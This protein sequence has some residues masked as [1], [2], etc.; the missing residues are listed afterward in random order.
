MPAIDSDIT[1]GASILTTSAG[2][3]PITQTLTVSG[4]VLGVP[5]ARVNRYLVVIQ[6]LA[7][8]LAVSGPEI[9][10]TADVNLSPATTPAWYPY[11]SAY[12]DPYWM[13]KPVIIELTSLNLRTV[14]ARERAWI[15]DEREDDDV[16]LTSSD[17]RVDASTGAHLTPT[18]L[19]ALEGP[20]LDAV[21]WPSATAYDDDLTELL[22][23]EPGRTYAGFEA[24]RDIDEVPEFRNSNAFAE[25][26]AIALF[27]SYVAYE[28]AVTAANALPPPS[29]TAALALTELMCVRSVPSPTGDDWEVCV[30]E[31]QGWFVDGSLNAV[32]DVDLSF[33]GSGILS[34]LTLGKA[35]G[36]VDVELTSA[37]IRWTG[38]GADCGV[39]EPRPEASLD[40]S[41]EVADIAGWNECPDLFVSGASALTT[42]EDDVA[43]EIAADPTLLDV[44]S[45]AAPS[46]AFTSTSTD[47]GSDTCA[48]A[49]LQP[50][51]NLFLGEFLPTLEGKLGPAWEP[52]LGAVPVTL[53]T[54]GGAAAIDAMFTPFELQ[55][56]CDARCDD[57]LWTAEFT[58]VA[59]RSGLLLTLETEDE[60]VTGIEFEDVKSHLPSELPFDVAGEYPGTND[61][62]D[63]MFAISTAELSQFLTA[64]TANSLTIDPADEWTDLGVDP[65][66]LGYPATPV[67]WD[68]RTLGAWFPTFAALGTSEVT[69]SLT[70]TTAAWAWMPVDA[71]Y[72]TGEYPVS[73]SLPQMELLLTED[74]GGG[75]TTTWLSAIVDFHDSDLQVGLSGDFASITLGSPVV[76]VTITE[77]LFTATCPRVAHAMTRANTSTACER[78]M[79]AALADLLQPQ[80]EALVLGMLDEVPALGGFNLAGYSSA[81]A[82]FSDVLYWQD[83]QY[84]AMFALLR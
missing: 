71:P 20:W 59:Y 73:V 77:S 58:D 55:P 50:D 76:F 79:E 15:S 54:H 60:P 14:Y 72:P 12:V 27:E 36:S 31:A 64:Q 44:F 3:D 51:I 38:G 45:T 81:G 10:W 9:V 70:P 24:C 46:F 32:T 43:V 22:V 66:A 26:Y 67:V 83:G 40:F 11:A 5:P 21:P 42:A 1:P 30:D 23:A 82:R 28:L 78:R 8:P 84:I 75:S 49:F 6:G 57:N 17:A 33:G 52:T 69:M 53:G 62:Y 48:D 19:D 4:T 13:D 47:T 80:I 34:D 35:T 7:V 39:L 63:V 18:G 2:Y 37:F 68:G 25:A 16:T 74:L 56:I 41:S 65:V 61:P 29:N